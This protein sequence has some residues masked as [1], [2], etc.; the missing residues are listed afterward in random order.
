MC[1]VTDTMCLVADTSVTDTMCPV[2][3]TM[4]LVTGKS[5]TDTM[6][7]ITDTICSVTDTMCPVTV[8]ALCLPTL[9]H[10][11]L[12]LWAEINLS[13]LKL[14]GCC[15]DSFGTANNYLYLTVAKHDKEERVCF[16]FRGAGDKFHPD[17]SGMAEGRRSQWATLGLK[18]QVMASCAQLSF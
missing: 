10:C 2:T 15:D 12:K 13:F 5:V 7:P 3:D 6:C 8:S 9:R 4:C 1:P 17:G 14:L 11:N 18:S 16:A